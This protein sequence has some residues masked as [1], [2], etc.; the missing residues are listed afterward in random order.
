M[1]VTLRIKVA[2]RQVNRLRCKNAVAQG[3]K[4]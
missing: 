3:R 1:N 4:L 2:K